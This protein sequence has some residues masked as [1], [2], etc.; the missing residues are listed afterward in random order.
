[1]GKA[2]KKP[3]K[4]ASVPNKS[5]DNIPGISAESSTQVRRSKRALDPATPAQEN[6]FFYVAV[7]MVLF[8]FALL[9]QL[10]DNI[11]ARYFGSGKDGEL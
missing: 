8:A 9:F 4:A 10:S 1:M 6:P 2:S 7:C 3:A 5:E 11:Y